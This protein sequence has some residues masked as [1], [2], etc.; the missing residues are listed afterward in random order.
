MQQED[1][2]SGRRLFFKILPWISLGWG[3]F[4][5]T[6]I[7]HNTRGIHKVLLF[8]GVFAL[9]GL[10]AFLLPRSNRAWLNWLTLTSQQTALQFILFF[11]LPLL[12]RAE[13]HVWVSIIAVLAT[14]TLWDPLF[15][16]LWKSSTYRLVMTLTCL[17]I[18]CG[19]FVVTWLPSQLAHSRT[20][21]A[22]LMLLA[23]L[24]VFANRGSDYW[25]SVFIV[26]VP[27]L[28]WKPV[29]LPPV[30]VW[31]SEGEI[32]FND[33]TR[34][35]ECVSRI[36]APHGFL[37]EIYH[38]WSIETHES[39][40]DLIKLPAVSGNGI[41]EKPYTTRSRKQEFARGYE[42]IKT[43]KITCTIELPNAGPIGRITYAGA[44]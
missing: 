8:M 12:W 34:S 10:L 27:L 33:D 24:S 1:E 3:L 30:G 14:S 19:L 42:E 37:S 39:G 22:G 32:K 17:S 44:L 35:V 16:Q 20:I 40:G 38:R 28:I 26:L 13:N 41:D 9:A 23:T 36:G 21:F 7:T 6:L 4:S 43:L 31:V 11:A 18:V 2:K 15:I 5:A 29:N 25:G